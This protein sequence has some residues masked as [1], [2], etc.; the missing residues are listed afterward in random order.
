MGK[1]KGFKP[2]RS[3]GV[4]P[5]EA[6]LVAQRMEAIRPGG[7]EVT[8]PRR[9]VWSVP[10]PESDTAAPV[11]IPI[12]DGYHLG[13]SLTRDSWPRWDGAL[14]RIAGLALGSRLPFDARVRAHGSD[15]SLRLTQPEHTDVWHEIGAGAMEKVLLGTLQATGLRRSP[16]TVRVT[17]RGLHLDDTNS[18]GTTLVAR[19]EAGTIRDDQQAIADE[20]ELNHNL[21]HTPRAFRTLGNIVLAEFDGVLPPKLADE[22]LDTSSV[23]DFPQKGDMVSVGALRLLD[24][25]RTFNRFIPATN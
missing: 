23:H 10:P 3:G 24:P 20:L 13:R 15:L 2:Q 25:A 1:S 14:D 18:A 8:T 12:N 16:R 22:L 4:P 5:E 19:L 6:A 11:R 17:F 7:G 21:P 9:H